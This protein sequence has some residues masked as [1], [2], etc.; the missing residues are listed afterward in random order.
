MQLLSSY[1]GHWDMHAM[2]LLGGQGIEGSM[3]EKD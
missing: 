3:E 2:P 1:D